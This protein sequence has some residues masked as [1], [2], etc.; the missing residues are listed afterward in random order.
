MPF[1]LTNASSTSM[2]KTLDEH[3][4]HFHVVVNV[5]RENKL[6][7]KLKKYSFFLESIVFLGFVVS[8]KGI[9]V[10][11]EKVKAIRE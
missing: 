11:E 6:Y 10:D 1:G 8:S 5:L 2:S 9:S 3:V 7:G 4:E